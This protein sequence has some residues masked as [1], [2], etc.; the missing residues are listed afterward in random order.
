MAVCRSRAGLFGQDESVLWS[1][2]I[3]VMWS[4]A[5]LKLIKWFDYGT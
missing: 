1:F 2:A 3:L 4:F 5:I